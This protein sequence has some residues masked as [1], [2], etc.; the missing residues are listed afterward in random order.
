MG[1]GGGTGIFIKSDIS[2]QLLEVPRST[3]LHTTYESLFV[4]ISLAK[5]SNAIIGAVYRPPGSSLGDFN[6]EFSELLT[7]LSNH[8]REIYLTGDFNI[9][10]LKS[11][12]H[13]MTNDFVNLILSHNLLPLIYKP[14]RI[15]VD[16]C[17][18]IDNILTNNWTRCVDSSVII[19]DISITYQ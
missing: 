10:L 1:R 5:D 17:T 6:E 3:H 15:T 16:S 11:E 18:L 14:T 9:D 19:S 13:P 2:Y 12:D 4:N 8:S 7:F